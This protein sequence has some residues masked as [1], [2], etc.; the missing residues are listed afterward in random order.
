[1]YFS[2]EKSQDIT[3][4]DPVNYCIKVNPDLYSKVQHDNEQNARVFLDTHLLRLRSSA[5]EDDLSRERVRRVVSKNDASV[6]LETRVFVPVLVYVTNLVITAE[7]REMS[8]D[9]FKTTYLAP[10]DDAL[11]ESNISRDYLPKEYG[12]PFG[13]A[14]SVESDIQDYFDENIAG[15]IKTLYHEICGIHHKFGKSSILRPPMNR[16]TIIKPDIVHVAKDKS[17]SNVQSPEV[18]FA[19]GDYK[20]ESYYLTQ[21]FEELKVVIAENKE[22]L[23]NRRTLRLLPNDTLFNDREWSPR[24]L[25]AL[26]LR[27]YIYQAFLC[28]TDR[29]FISDHQSFSGFFKYEFV[30]GERMVINYYVIND[31]ETVEHGITLRSAIA[32]FFYKQNADVLDT[33]ERLTKILEVASKTEGSDPFANV[34]PRPVEEPTRKRKRSKSSGRALRSQLPSIEENTDDDDFDEIHG[35]TYCRI[36]YDAPKCFPGLSSILPTN[37]FTKLYNYPDLAFENFPEKDDYYDMFV[38][39]LEINKIIA[40]SQFASNFPKLIVSGY[41]NGMPS[42]PMHIFEDL[43]EE[44]PMSEWDHDKVYDVIKLRLKE[45]HHLGISHNDVRPANIVVAETGKISLIDFGLST[46]PSCEKRKKSDF[47]ALDRSFNRASYSI[48]EENEVDLDDGDSEGTKNNNYASGRNGMFNSSNEGIFDN[49]S[50]ESQA[51]GSTKGDIS[52]TS[53]QE[54]KENDKFTSFI[55]P[56]TQVLQNHNQKQV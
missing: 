56:G 2:G 8:C 50:K 5:P 17:A 13:D 30:D 39:E 27:K 43:G 53:Q 22:S 49:V 21:G 1:M 55:P 45:L 10:L 19:I 6:S 4:D 38:N 48:Q 15:T 51:T 14:W 52:S 35:N 33:K 36:I 54:N 20:K 47:A 24:V 18:C 26:V 32:G 12:Y 28:G 29:V 34:V 25:Y 46:Y 44:V 7:F 3:F 23:S 41:L 11:R 37:V 42:K 9:E 31:P 16:T 40:N